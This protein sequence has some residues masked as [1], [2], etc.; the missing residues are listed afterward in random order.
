MIEAKYQAG[1]ACCF[2]FST[3]KSVVARNSK[4]NG[5]LSAE[6]KIEEEK[7]DVIVKD[8]RTFGVI[9]K[10]NKLKKALEEERR[11][12]KE[13]RRMVRFATLESAK[14]DAQIL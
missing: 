6:D 1:S 7:K 14:L 9:E 5:V 3:N 4:S 11:I 12:S 10:E 8:C 13:G 2:C